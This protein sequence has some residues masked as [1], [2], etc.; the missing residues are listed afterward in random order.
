M[1]WL[2]YIPWWVWPVLLGGGGVAL[3][4]FVPGIAAFALSIY[5]MLPSWARWLI[6]GAFVALLAYLRGRNIGRDNATAE[7]RKVDE[8]SS[9]AAKEVDR[10]V[11]KLNDDEVDRELEK[12]GG[13]W[14]P[15]DGGSR[16]GRRP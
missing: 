16:R 4:V 3:W 14:D 15:P 7:Q 8:K 6:G 2:D 1:E 10:R 12:G 11:E 9:T 13:F 5:N